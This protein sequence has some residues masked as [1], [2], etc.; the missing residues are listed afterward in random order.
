M[1][2]NPSPSMTLAQP[3]P[4]G[5]GGAT[6]DIGSQMRK[7]PRSPDP[8]EGGQCQSPEAK[9]RSGCGGSTTSTLPGT[10]EYQQWLQS[11]MQQLVFLNSTAQQQQ[12]FFGYRF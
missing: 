9:R 7:R 1:F 10:L 4:P 12:P 8:G 3:I 6:A 11:A 5:T 2:S